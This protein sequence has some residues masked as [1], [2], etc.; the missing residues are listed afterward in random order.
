VEALLWHGDA[1][2][3]IVIGALFGLFITGVCTIAGLKAQSSEPLSGRALALHLLLFTCYAPIVVFIVQVLPERLVA[4]RGSA[5]LFVAV[6]LLLAAA[7][8]MLLVQRRAIRMRALVPPAIAPRGQLDASIAAH[9]ATYAASD[10]YHRAI[11]QLEEQGSEFC[12]VQYRIAPYFLPEAAVEH[13]ASLRFGAG[14]PLKE[15]YI[16]A[17]RKRRDAFNHLIAR[18]ARVREIYPR[19]RLVSYIK[20]GTHLGEMWPLTP[21]QMV[22]LLSGWRHAIAS[23]PNYTVAIADESV[24]MKYHLIDEKA[25][26]LHE[27]IGRG[28]SHRLNSVFILNETIGARFSEDFEMVWDL[29][30]PAWR[31]SEKIVS[32]I[33]TTLIPDAKA[34]RPPSIAPPERKDPDGHPGR[35]NG[36]RKR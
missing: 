13:V 25:V 15:K 28:D 26:I 19:S 1:Q 14:S 10:A 7:V 8:H 22:E 4:T 16:E 35:N 27:P 3:G 34:P 17:Q 31:D 24:P 12:F 36:K 18:G 33:D 30:E 20:T 11:V 6:L 2:S 29:I 9:V 5:L 23:F 32:W 21:D